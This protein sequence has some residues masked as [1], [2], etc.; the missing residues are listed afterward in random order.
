MRLLIIDDHELF[1][2]GFSALMTELTSDVEVAHAADVSEAALALK[3]ASFDL[4]FLDWWLGSTS[5][6]QALESILEL[7]P[8]ARIVILSGERSQQVVDQAIGQ[9]ACGFIPKGSSKAQLVEALRI[10]VR[11][12]I[13]LPAATLLAP[14]AA[15]PSAPVRSMGQAFPELTPRQA[16]VLRVAL[17]GQSNKEIARE[18]GIGVATVATHLVA[19]YSAIGAKNRTE[20]VYLAA[21][22]GAQII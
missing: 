7:A 20:A 3:D 16:D 21:Q 14:P 17:R 19:V 11:G 6:S 2:E 5:G 18:L 1:R 12:G 13:F 22:R 15:P 10:I 9:G 8:R 4:V